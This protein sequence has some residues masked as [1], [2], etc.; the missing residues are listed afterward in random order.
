MFVR[1]VLQVEPIVAH[2][3]GQ[4]STLPAM[5][6]GVALKV[7]PPRPI[8][9]TM[10]TRPDD[11][12][13][14]ARRALRTLALGALGRRE[15]GRAKPALVTLVRQ[16]EAQSAP[17][18][19][20]LRARPSGPVR[21][22]LSGPLGNAQVLRAH[23][24]AGE[25]V[26]VVDLADGADA[27]QAAAFRA[28]AEAS[29]RFAAGVPGMLRVHR[30]SSN[31][32]SYVADL[33][34][35]GTLVD[36]PALGW[37]LGARLEI[38]ERIAHTVEAMHAR[39]IVH[40]RLWPGFVLLDDDLH[41]VVAGLGLDPAT[42]DAHEAARYF[43]P[44]ARAHAHDDARADVYSLG[45]LL[46]FLLTADRAPDDSGV[47]VRSDARLRALHHIASQATS[48]LP[49]AR[50]SSVAQLLLEVKHAMT[51]TTAPPARDATDTRNGSST[52][53]RSRSSASAPGSGAHRAP[54]TANSSWRR[55]RIVLALGLSLVLALVLLLV[56]ASTT[57]WTN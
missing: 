37:D 29:V 15:S 28:G 46:D 12:A 35:V 26:A 34:T 20:T 13:P 5:P 1:R 52:P 33:W 21:E 9:S 6:A 49:Q 31:G 8:T 3:A 11:R 55:S 54:H 10:T 18:P 47:R 50:P 41:P 17:A 38:F 57:G 53:S 56:L 7:A 36:L 51:P 39:G 27:R 43:A 22:G 42:A 2:T 23:D 45:R 30:I 48:P 40:G 25:A 24:E 32:R 44:E 4:A 19:V 16:V 14:P